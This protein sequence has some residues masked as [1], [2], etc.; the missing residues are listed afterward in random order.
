M[1]RNIFKKLKCAALAGVAIISGA[2][3]VTGMVCAPVVTFADEIDDEH[4]Y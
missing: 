1:K 2:G 4:L 3:T